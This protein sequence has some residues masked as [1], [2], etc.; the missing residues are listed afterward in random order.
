MSM[1]V[2][3]SEDYESFEPPFPF[4][5]D[6]WADDWSSRLAAL[7]SSRV[8][9]REA[10]K[11][12]QDGRRLVDLQVA[13]PPI[14]VSSVRKNAKTIAERLVLIAEIDEVHVGFCVSSVGPNEHDPLF[15]QLVGVVPAAQRRGVG[16]AL[17]TSAA[18]REPQRDIA[19][20]TQDDNAAARAMNKRFAASIGADIQRVR[21]GTYPN[22]DLGIP[23]GMGYRAW[24]IQRSPGE[25]G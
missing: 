15:V 14:S 25:Q 13:C 23:T 21:S 22:S 18:G 8:S 5:R 6:P 9:I 17:L 19:L 10:R 4:T 24:L 7:T 16:L 2:D 20:A 11:V 1:T 12:A 3:G